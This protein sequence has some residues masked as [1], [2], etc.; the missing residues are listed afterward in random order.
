MNEK[1]KIL[2]VLG[3]FAVI[4]A[5]VILAMIQNSMKQQKIVN[6]FNEA[7]S[8]KTEQ[9]V[10]LERPGCSAC[11]S[12][13]PTLKEV[14]DS[15]QLS[16]VDINTDDIKESK[17]HNI[18]NKLGIDWESF[19]TPTIAVVKDNKVIKSSVGV[20]SKEALITLL[21]DSNVISE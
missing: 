8:S 4:I 15:Y 21:K 6:K 14:I 5:L 2:I 12:F 7:F 1:K 3:I 17:L 20:L 19:G 10:Y 9:I 11:L 13:Q 16:Y 18:V